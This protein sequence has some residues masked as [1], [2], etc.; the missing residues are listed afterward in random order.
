MICTEVDSYF[1]RLCHEQ[2]MISWVITLT[3][4]VKVYGDYD[5]SG[6]SNPWVRIKQHCEDNEVWPKKV[7]LYMF[8]AEK[9][10]FFE[11]ENGLDGIAIMRGIAKDQAMDGSHSQSFQTLSVLHLRDDCSMID[12]AKYTWPYNDFEQKESE[13]LLTTENLQNMIFKNGSEKRQHEKVKEYL[14]WGPV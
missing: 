1:Y 14:D 3:D 11:D 13:R 12:V 6:L 9:K 5:R 4:N 2:L 10:V 7:E 8:G